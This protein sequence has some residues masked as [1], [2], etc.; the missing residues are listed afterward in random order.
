MTTVVH[1]LS[2]LASVR[3]SA[4]VMRNGRRS[5]RMIGH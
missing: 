3:P 2:D 5:P 4:K 1:A